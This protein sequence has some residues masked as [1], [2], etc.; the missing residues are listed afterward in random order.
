MR[1][2]SSATRSA[3]T[4]E[5]LLTFLQQHSIDAWETTPGYVDALRGQ[6]G[7]AALL[8]ARDPADPFVLLLGGEA[9][10]PGAVGMGPAAT[11]VHGWN[12]YGP[13]EAGVDTLVA[14]MD[15]SPSPVLGS[16]TS[17]TTAHVLDARL[18]PVPVGSIGELWLSG[19]QLAD[20]YIGN[21]AATA[22]RF[23]A[24]PFTGDGSR[25]YRTGDL[26]V[27]RD[28][29]GE[30]TMPVVALGRSDDQVKIRGHRIEPGEVSAVIAE[31]EDVSRAVVRP[32]DS[33]RGTVLAAWVVP[34]ELADAAEL[35]DRLDQLTSSRLPE[36]M[37]PATVTLV[38]EI[39]LT[40]NGRSMLELSR[41]RARRRVGP[42]APRRY[43]DRR[44]RSL[45]RGA[46]H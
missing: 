1:C 38:T 18:R 37:R 42:R 6:T 43:R 20:G 7:L 36:Y 22:A 41:P 16:P 44:R 14:S 17:G 26:I 32:I 13:T 30:G 9:I 8:D 31:H 4:P 33:P 46:R 19:P 24:D 2:T 5:S 23:V 10:G 34:T 45:R 15:S 11:A 12:L 3:V 21:P 35:P 39:P 40:S 27:V 28:A 25:M 29:T